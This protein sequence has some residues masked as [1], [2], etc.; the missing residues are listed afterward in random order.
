MN[1]RL[2]Q[3][4]LSRQYIYIYI[5]IY[6]AYG[7]NHAHNVTCLD[8]LNSVISANRLTDK[9][10][11]D[12][13]RNMISKNPSQLR[14]CI[15]GLSIQGLMFLYWL[16]IQLIGTAI[17][18]SNISRIISLKFMFLFHIL[19]LVVILIFLLYI[20]LAQCLNQPHFTEISELIFHPLISPMNLILSLHIC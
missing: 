15:I 1:I 17:P 4:L 12:F 13:Y 5:Y 6:N 7:K 9:A 10:K 3:L 2:L 8:I 20:T 16:M 11:S 18:F 19:L 14:N